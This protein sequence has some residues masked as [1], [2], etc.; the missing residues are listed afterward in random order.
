MLWNAGDTMTKLLRMARDFVFIKLDYILFRKTN[1]KLHVQAR[2]C[3]NYIAHGE[4]WP[5]VIDKLI[6]QRIFINAKV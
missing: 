1:A 6:K 2:K 3:V 4:Q 5:P